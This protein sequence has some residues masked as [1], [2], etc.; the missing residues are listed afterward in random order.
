[1]A[2]IKSNKQVGQDIY[3]LEIEG[4]YIAKPGQFYMIKINSTYPLLSRPISIFE[5]TNNSIKFLYRIVGEGT[6]ILSHKKEGDEL[7]LRG[8]YGNGFPYTK[9]KVALVGGGMGVAPLYETSKQL[10]INSDITAVDLYL[11]F[12][13]ECI[14]KDEWEKVCSSF[15]YDIGGFITDHIDVT[16]YDVIMTCGPDIMMKKLTE[17]GKKNGVKVY[18]SKE[19]RMA[20][21]V[22]ACLVCNCKTKDGNK[23]VCKDGPVFLGEEIYDV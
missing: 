19:S 4:K 8:P 21:G 9:G 18:V 7:T 2:I 20:C 17:E 22:G 23:K 15:F 10:K 12:S 1:M 6:D 11:G 13:Q 14:L 3:L 16:K 5:I